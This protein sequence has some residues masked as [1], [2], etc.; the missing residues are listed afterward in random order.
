MHI[1]FAGTFSS[2]LRPLLVFHICGWRFKSRMCTT[3]KKA[4]GRE[5]SYLPC[6]LAVDFVKK[7]LMHI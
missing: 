1:F 3:V 2:N 5:Q 6:V 4:K 7:S